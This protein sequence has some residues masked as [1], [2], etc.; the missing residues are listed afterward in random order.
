MSCDCS[1]NAVRMS[2]NTAWIG[3][4]ADEGCDEVNGIYFF[5]AIYDVFYT[6]TSQGYMH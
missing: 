6:N 4:V 5:I 3:N 1:L 2:A